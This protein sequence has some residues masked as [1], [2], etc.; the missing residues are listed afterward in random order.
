MGFNI[1]TLNI[2][3]INSIVPF[4]RKNV[5]LILFSVV[6]QLAVTKNPSEF[7]ATVQANKINY[8]NKCYINIITHTFICCKI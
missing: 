4:K 3:A 8:N 7:T 6:S 1:I 2:N 5:C